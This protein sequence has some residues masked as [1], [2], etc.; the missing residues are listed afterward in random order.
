MIE[1]V[2][3]DV[4]CSSSTSEEKT[5]YHYYEA[6]FKIFI[7]NFAASFS[8]FK[9]ADDVSK[10]TRSLLFYKIEHKVTHIRKQLRGSLYITVRGTFCAVELR[11]VTFEERQSSWFDAKAAITAIYEDDYLAYDD[12]DFT[13][14]ETPIPPFTADEHSQ[15]AAMAF[16]LTYKANEHLK[17]NVPYRFAEMVPVHKI[18][19]TIAGWSIFFRTSRE[20]KR[21]GKSTMKR[22]VSNVTGVA[23]NLAMAT[24]MKKPFCQDHEEDVVL[25]GMASVNG[26]TAAY[27]LRELETYMIV[28]LMKK[29]TDPGKLREI[30]YLTTGEMVDYCEEKA[31][32]QYSN[33]NWVSLYSHN[34]SMAC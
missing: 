27:L 11:Q 14:L 22:A 19:P 4:V 8:V 9:A 21:K 5:T 24:S 15:F 33:V 18:R 20:G 17:G 16:T 29:F 7:E 26:A 6:T 13:R 30:R 32:D 28:Y 12:L 23:A 2:S 31:I 25:Y 3:A 1:S 10:T 34:R